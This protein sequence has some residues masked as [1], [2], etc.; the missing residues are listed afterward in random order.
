MQPMQDK[1][2]D[3]LFKDQFEHAEI[4]PSA[5]LWTNISQELA[6]RKKR[7]LPIY[8]SAAAAVF[9]IV[10]ISL[11]YPKAEKMQ[12]Q[13][14]TP[15]ADQLV[16]ENQIKAAAVLELPVSEEKSTPL[17]LAPK[18]KL[19]NQVKKDNLLAMQPNDI[20]LHPKNTTIDVQPVEKKELAQKEIDLNSVVFAKVDG[21]EISDVK[22]QVSETTE[23][24][25]IRNVGDVINFV[26]DKFDK[27][28]KKIIQFKTDDDDNSS[29]IAINIGILKFNPKRNK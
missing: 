23:R 6:P 22:D 18:L 7:S 4:Q 14:T 12:L 21:P 24:K 17:V 2:F 1:D 13:G 16:A 25:G 3:Q 19:E 11:L 9:V 10:T 26:V 15:V 20:D 8:W 28:E 27:R 29:L 5:N